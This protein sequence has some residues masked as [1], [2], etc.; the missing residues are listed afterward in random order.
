MACRGENDQG[1]ETGPEP[2]YYGYNSP[3][4]TLDAAKRIKMI[5]R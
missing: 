5:K 4:P 2:E 1:E 3:S